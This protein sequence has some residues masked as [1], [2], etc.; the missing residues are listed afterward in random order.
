MSKVIDA[1]EA[2][3]ARL[4]DAYTDGALDL[5]TWKQ[6]RETVEQEAEH[7]RARLTELDAEPQQAP[8]A[9]TI[10]TFADTWPTLS[11]DARRDVAAALLSSLRV[12]PDK[13]VE[14]LPRRGAP[15][16]ITF[17]NRGR[18]PAPTPAVE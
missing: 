13:T 5:L 3:T 10:T 15:V 12:N 4:L 11:G 1:A 14:L 6:R 16:T 2:K 17:T 9:A 7:A 8:S 18:L